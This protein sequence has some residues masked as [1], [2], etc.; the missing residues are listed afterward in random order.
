MRQLLR[1][2]YS[3]R[4]ASREGILQSWTPPAR[5]Q[6]PTGKAKSRVGLRATLLRM[7]A[8]QHAQA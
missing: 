1:V 8:S 6:A 4:L 5:V 3:G 2:G 7:Q